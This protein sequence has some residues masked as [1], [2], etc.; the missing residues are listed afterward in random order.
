MEYFYREWF[1]GRDDM[2]L[3]QMQYL[4]AAVE[5]KSLN[6]AA[7][8]LYT[9]QPNVSKVIRQLEVELGAEILIRSSKGISLTSFGEQIYVYA[10]HMVKDMDMI[11]Q[12]AKGAIYK[13]LKIA[14][15]PSNMI[16]RNLTDFYMDNRN[17]NI[18]IEFNEGT[19]EEVIDMVSNDT[20]HIGIIYLAKKQM[21][22][23]KRIMDK[24][25]LQFTILR[26]CELCIYVGPKHQY[27]GDNSINFEEL[28]N[29]CFIQ[30]NKD[31]FSMA[32]QL[33]EFSLG[34]VRTEQLNH[35]VHTNS[36]HCML[37]MLLY[38]DLCS[39]GLDFMNSKYL[40]YDISMVKI[41]HC[42]RCLLV[43]YVSKGEDALKDYERLYIK[44]LKKLFL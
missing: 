12:L 34:S 18:H 30:G 27:F 32:D 29:L 2:E 24:K 8:I 15:Y 38:T 7:E 16:A 28:N 19:A 9:S 5:S 43:G 33:H 20:A 39:M 1:K 26:E 31:Y 21:Q 3:K 4:I 14:S 41:N 10:C 6:K 22:V 37:D 23:L 25:N 44:S 17:N 40:Q 35:V 11:Q 36:D 42:D 13:K